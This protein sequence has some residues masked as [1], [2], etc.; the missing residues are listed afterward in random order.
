M[1][2]NLSTRSIQR[3]L[4]NSTWDFGNKV[5][6]DLCRRHPTHAQEDIAIAK[7][8]LIGRSYS[9]AIERR[10]T[11]K[12]RGADAFYE[13]IVG[14]RISASRIDD[15]F[16]TLRDDRT[17]DRNLSLA[18]H[19]KVTK[20]FQKITGMDKRSLASKYLHFHFPRRFYIYDSRANL[21]IRRLTKR[22]KDGVVITEDADHVFARFW[23]CCEELDRRIASR[24]GRHLSPR[25]LDKVLLAHSFR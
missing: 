6:Y 7:V 10:R 14:P 23:V 18:V 22:P 11:V 24:W 21:A 4:S 8:W 25:E 17:N 12:A 13:K 3:A 1:K 20:L 15:W 16:Q 19:A 2:S 9:A 5:L